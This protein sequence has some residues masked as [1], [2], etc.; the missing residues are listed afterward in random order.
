[1]KKKICHQFSQTRAP[2][3]FFILSNFV[4]PH[5]SSEAPSSCLGAGQIF[6]CVKTDRFSIYKPQ[7]KEILQSRKFDFASSRRPPKYLIFTRQSNS[8]DGTCAR[9]LGKFL[10]AFATVDHWIKKIRKL[11]KDSIGPPVIRDAFCNKRHLVGRKKKQKKKERKSQTLQI[12]CRLRPNT[13]I[14]IS[15]WENCSI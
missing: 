7:F 1:M 14:R 3:N 5:Q 4:K 13:G 10:L 2:S 6:V 12:G 11:R 8:Q 9:D 15:L